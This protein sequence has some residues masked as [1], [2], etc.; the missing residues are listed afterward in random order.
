[1]IIDDDYPQH[2]LFYQQASGARASTGGIS[3]ATR[4]FVGEA[5]RSAVCSGR[6]PRGG[7]DFQAGADG[8]GGR[9]ACRISLRGPVV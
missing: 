1:M 2:F 7:I 8:S 5:L 3:V 9:L 4:F 6:M